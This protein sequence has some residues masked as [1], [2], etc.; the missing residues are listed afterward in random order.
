MISKELTALENRIRSSATDG[1]TISTQLETNQ[2]IIARVTDGIY[3]EPWA[4]FRELI[5]N[6]Y[7]ADASYVVV[8]TDPPRFDQITVRDDGL[9]M[10]PGTLA[11]VLKNIG[12]SSKRTPIGV[13]LNTSQP[14]AYD[15]S[16]G[17]RPLIGKIGIGL[18][19][20]AQLT[21]HF[22]VITKARG[23]MLKTSATV[24][25]RTHDETNFEDAGYVAGSVTI[26]S[27]VVPENEKDNHGTTVVLYSLRPDV[28][29]A[30]RSTPRWN[31]VSLGADDGETIQETPLYHIGYTSTEGGDLDGIEPALPWQAS[32]TPE[33]KFKRL[34]TAAGDASRRGTKAADLEHFDEYL[35][36][37]WKLSLSLPIG[38]IQKHPFDVRG[39]DGLIVYALPA[40]T[41]QAEEVTL[42][43]QETV[44]E[45]LGLHAGVDAPLDDFSVTIDGVRLSRPVSLPANLLRKRS[46]IRAP[47]MMV[48][49]RYNPFSRDVVERAGGK[50]SFEAYLYWNSQI[51][52]KE[53][54]GV[55]VRIR[56]T[57]GTL[58]DRTFLN[59]QVSEQT[60]LRQITAEIFVKEGLDSALNIDRESYN[61]SHPHFLYIQRWLHSALRL[62]INR[63]KALSTEDLRR[64]RATE[65]SRAGAVLYTRAE[66]I[67]RRRYGDDVD[68]PVPLSDPNVAADEVGGTEIGWGE[69]AMQD[70]P[71]KVTALSIVLEAYGVL[72]ALPFPDRTQ[73]INDILGLFE[74]S[75]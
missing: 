18:F 60:R 55:L 67:W 51:A 75:E 74:L 29:R 73:I 7:D 58:F 49:K 61:F 33:W 6:S 43:T 23:E 72:S 2:K 13:D 16:P 3:R 1:S 35:K 30:M 36:L 42:Q 50:L 8:E 62:F 21:Q 66:D 69:G 64:E 52:P 47:V 68:P 14:G 71:L 46:R 34:L 57:S 39:S 9:G 4:A 44:R 28:K 45:H 31:S 38:Y 24:V 22:Q 63:L 48:D 56:E 59:Y 15:R 20:V 37:I 41:G 65:R 5:A 27:E 70:E 54:A 25:L 40:H 53:N 12:G 11:Y 10:S 19:A 17:G 32:D 26:K